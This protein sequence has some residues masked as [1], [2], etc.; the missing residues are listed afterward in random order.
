MTPRLK[1]AL[2]AG[3][4]AIAILAVMGWARKPAAPAPYNTYSTSPSSSYDTTPATQ[5]VNA[6]SASAVT[7]AGSRVYDDRQSPEVQSVAYRDT[8]P[9]IE[10]NGYARP[11][12]GSA[13]RY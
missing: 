11:N 8:N 4:A 3:F 7:P 13:D 2:A 6:Y 9:C 12:T 5:P 10:P 1:L